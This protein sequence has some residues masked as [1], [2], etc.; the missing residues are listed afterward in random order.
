MSDTD[1]Q[2]MIEGMVAGLAAR[3]AENPD[4][5]EGWT[6]LARSYS[7]LGQYDK[8]ASA[9]EEAIE[10]SPDDIELRL[11]R[12]EA[13]LN[14]LDAAGEPL[15]ETARAAVGDVARLEPKHPFALYFQ[16]LAASQDGDNDTARRYW[17]ELLEAM[18]ADA[19]ETAQVKAMIDAL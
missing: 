16:G 4:D 18:P 15:D 11:G 19:P 14:K 13:L 17:T 12:A 7:V 10:L 1:R 6:M 5:L 8:S 3:L 9:F 2:Q